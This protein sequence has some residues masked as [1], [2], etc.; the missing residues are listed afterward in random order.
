VK[1]GQTRR[2]R[3][4]DASPVQSVDRAIAILYLLAERGSLGVTEVAGELGV[5]K[6]TAFRLIA[7]LENRDL[8]E[9]TEERG[10]YHLGRGIVRLAGATSAQLEVSTESRPV[11]RRLAVELGETVNV[12]ILDAGGATNVMQE[13]GSAAISGRNWIGQ[14]TPLHATASGKVLLSWTDDP[15]VKAILDGELERF[16]ART[17]TDPAVLGAE[18]AEARSRGWAATTEELE[19]GLSAVAAP[20]RD[21][22]G[23]VVAAVGISGPAYRLTAET[24]PEVAAVLVEG[25]REI[26]ARMGYYGRAR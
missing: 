11:C 16:T 7:A 6:S 4:S 14:Q 15:Q 19:E 18:L 8:L 24:F 12:A 23:R 9:Q 22:T 5:H 3:A 2:D 21:A 25:A 13:Y 10:G 17:I 26:S 20:V 1:N